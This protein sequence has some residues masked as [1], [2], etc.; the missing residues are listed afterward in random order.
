M[1]A[2]QREA[3]QRALYKQERQVQL[4]WAGHCA[5]GVSRPTA[6]RASAW[7]D[8]Y[9]AWQA[10]AGTRLWGARIAEHAFSLARICDQP[11]QDT[12][13]SRR[14]CCRLARHI[15]PQRIMWERRCC[16][17]L[18]SSQPSCKM[19]LC[20]QSFECETWA[21]FQLGSSQHLADL[22]RSSIMW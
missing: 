2:H 8:I 20:N 13:G 11:V 18:L 9:V 5:L 22:G 15:F 19:H 14:R 1:T 17:D 7:W 12:T 21:Q 16:M 6:Q 4:F 3:R 10:L